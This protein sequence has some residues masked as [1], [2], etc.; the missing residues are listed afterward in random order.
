MYFIGMF[1][2]NFYFKTKNKY[3]ANAY[4]IEQLFFISPKS[5]SNT[6]EPT[7]PDSG[8]HRLKLV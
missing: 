8:H 7:L 1:P 4:H 5:V 3:L 2:F 6:A